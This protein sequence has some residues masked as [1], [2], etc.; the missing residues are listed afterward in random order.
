MANI[1]GA[2]LASH[3]AAREAKE[4]STAC[5]AARAAG[6]AAA[7]A[8]ISQHVHQPNSREHVSLSIWNSKD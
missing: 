6:Q 5:F 3:A 7:T 8:H 2:S 4:N 1:H